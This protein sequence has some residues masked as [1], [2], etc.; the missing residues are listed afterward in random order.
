MA[1]IPCLEFS[2]VRKA[3]ELIVPAR[4]AT[5][6]ELKQLSDIDDQ[7]GLWFQVPLIFFYKSNP[8]MQGKDPVKVI[9]QALSRVLVF[10][11]PLAGRLREG[12][13]GKTLV[14]CTDEGVLFIEADANV[15]LDQFGD[16]AI[17]PPSPYFDQLLHNVPGSDGIIGCPLLLFQVSLLTCGIQ[18][19]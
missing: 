13:N 9:K 5:S 6:R 1:S 19:I 15:K 8:S 14:D 17:Q 11:Y 7:Q 2:V 18:Y 4:R 3:P 16:H 10:Y 12:F